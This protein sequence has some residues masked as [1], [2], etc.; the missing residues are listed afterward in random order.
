MAHVHTC[1]QNC[2]GIYDFN[3]DHLPDSVCI[4]DSTTKLS[5]KRNRD[6]GRYANKK[7]SDRH[8]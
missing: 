1:T 4:L 5:R 7:E 8:T 6:T 3:W 2:A